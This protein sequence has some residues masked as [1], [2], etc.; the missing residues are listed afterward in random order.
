[1]IKIDIHVRIEKQQVGVYEVIYGRY[2]KTGT[3]GH[4]WKGGSSCDGKWCFSLINSD[5]TQVSSLL[6]ADAL[7]DMVK[8]STAVS[9][10]GEVTELLTT[11]GV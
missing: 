8:Q 6:F 5:H 9:Y 3:I 4:I 2:A 1:M 7:T 11:D 10:T